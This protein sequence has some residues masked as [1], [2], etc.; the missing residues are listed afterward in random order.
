MD[1]DSVTHMTHK[2]PDLKSALPGQPRDGD[3][4][5]LVTH[6]GPPDLESAMPWKPPPRRR[7]DFQTGGIRVTESLSHWARRPP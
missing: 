3:S 2:S 4:V 5:T 7:T 1:R 6:K